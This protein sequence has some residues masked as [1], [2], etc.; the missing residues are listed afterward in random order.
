M[1]LHAWYHRQQA[2]TIKQMDS[3]Q[4]CLGVAG[5]TAGSHAW[6]VKY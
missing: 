6:L 1:L 4:K 5:A 3:G 2:I